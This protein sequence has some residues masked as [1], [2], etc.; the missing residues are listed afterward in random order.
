MNILVYGSNGWIGNQFI[1]I[2][3][4]RKKKYTCGKSRVD[5]INDLREEIMNLGNKRN[6]LIREIHY[7]RSTLEDAYIE[8]IQNKEK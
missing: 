3:K 1:E 5:N 2:L 8:M 6:W 7:Q 4:Q